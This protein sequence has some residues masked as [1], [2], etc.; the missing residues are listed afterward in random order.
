MCVPYKSCFYLKK[1]RCIICVAGTS[2]NNYKSN[3]INNGEYFLM[4]KNFV[5]IQTEYGCIQVKVHNYFN[6]Y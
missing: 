4:V 5:L 3:I 2:V 1:L 6:N